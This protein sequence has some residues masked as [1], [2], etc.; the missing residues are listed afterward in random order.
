MILVYDFGKTRV[1]LPP[2]PHMK[3][4]NLHTIDERYHHIND[5]CPDCK[6]GTLEFITAVFPWST[7][8]LQCSRDACQGTYVLFCD[9]CI[10]IGNKESL[11]D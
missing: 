8:H 6:L 7:E 11:S 10:K 2:P 5:I 3:S 9:E 4:I 1:R